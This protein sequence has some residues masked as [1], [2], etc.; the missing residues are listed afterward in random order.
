MNREI[1][2]ETHTVQR[3]QVEA[4][5]GSLFCWPRIARTTTAL[6][7]LLLF[8]KADIFATFRYADQLKHR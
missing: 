6:T 1:Y 8:D 4:K 2:D 7:D 5:P 3:F